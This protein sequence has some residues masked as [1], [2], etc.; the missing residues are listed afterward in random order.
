METNT[1]PAA[2][3]DTPHV[4]QRVSGTN[5]VL[6]VVLTFGISW[7]VWLGLRAL[8]VPF[9][10]YAAAGMFGPAIAAVLLRLLR[11]EGFADAGLRLVGRGHRGGGWMYLAA[12]L[13]PPLLIAVGILLSLLIG[14]QHWAFSQNIQAQAQAIVKALHQ[15]G[16]KLPPGYTPEQLALL[17]V[18]S[19]SAL[20]FTLAIPFNMIFTF[21]EE[22]G[23]RGYL[24]PKLAPLSGVAAAIITGVIWGL[25]HAPLIV[26]D[27][28]NYPGYPLL[29][30]P[31]MVVF[32]MSLG[33]IFAWLR[34]RSGSVWP[35]TLAHAAINAQAGFGLLVLSPGNPLLRPPIGLIGLAP[36]IA[37]AIWLIA[38]GR[39]RPAQV[40]PVESGNVEQRAS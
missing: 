39:L 12:Y 25:W 4:A 37:F 2:T 15:Q 14:Y 6:F 1:V 35:S 26:L 22:F 31:M 32:T 10:I 20:A 34:F 28:Y 40:P 24:L 27:G 8:G 33:V 9:T 36:M 13:A 16:A 3:V 30:V 38:S 18:V 5:I 29:G 19:Q 11:K 21:G 7:L 23:W 17:S